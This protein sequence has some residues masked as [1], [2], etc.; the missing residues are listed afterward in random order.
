MVRE[1]ATAAVLLGG[2]TGGWTFPCTRTAS[3]IPSGMVKRVPRGAKSTRRGRGETLSDATRLAALIDTCETALE[4][5]AV[6]RRVATTLAK[7]LG[8]ELAFRWQ[9][10]ELRAALAAPPPLTDD[11]WIRERYGEL[12]DKHRDHALHMSVL[13]AVGDEIRRLE[14]EGVLPASMVLRA[15]RARRPSVRK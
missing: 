12:V 15:P 2:S 1:S 10:V 5:V 9:L 14:R 6:V 4:H 11:D 7:K 3:L 13:R 8:G